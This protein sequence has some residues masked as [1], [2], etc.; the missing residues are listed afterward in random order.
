MRIYVY[1]FIYM[2]VL[3]DFEISKETLGNSKEGKRVKT[4]SLID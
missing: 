2:Y 4:H 3:I 1:I